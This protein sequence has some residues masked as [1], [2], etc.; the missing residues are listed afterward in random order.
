M[1]SKSIQIH[2]IPDDSYYRD[3]M[4]TFWQDECQ[5]VYQQLKEKEDGHSYKIDQTLK[6]GAEHVRDTNVFSVLSMAIAS[7]GGFKTFY[8]VIKLWIDYKNANREKVRV[9]I[10]LGDNEID[11]SNIKRDEAFMLVQKYIND[12]P[13]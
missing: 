9:K 2:L 3:K 10:K 6:C 13:K 5:Q 4:D 7:I 8:E 11:I 12:F 1:E